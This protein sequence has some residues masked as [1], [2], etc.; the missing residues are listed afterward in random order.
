MFNFNSLW[1]DAHSSHLTCR[2]LRFSRRKDIFARWLN[3]LVIV[4]MLAG[5]LPPVPAQA[6]NVAQPA[7][8]FK[9]V[10]YLQPDNNLSSAPVSMTAQVLPGAVISDTILSETGGVM[11]DFPS[12]E[13]ISVV[14]SFNIT[15]EASSQ[16]G[17][18]T[19][20]TDT[21]YYI[22]YV[23]GS[24]GTI[25]N[26]H[27]IIGSPDGLRATMISS[28]TT[29]KYFTF[30]P[31]EVLS[32]TIDINI[33]SSNGS[34][35]SAQEFYI[36]PEH[37]KSVGDSGWQYVSG[38]NNT[39]GPIVTAQVGSVMAGFKADLD[40]NGVAW[41]DLDWMSFTMQGQGCL[42]TVLPTPQTYAPN[43][44]P[45]CS[46]EQRQ[47]HFGGPINSFSGNYGYQATD[48]NIATRGQ[49]LRLE[50]SYN[51]Q[52]ADGSSDI[53]TRPLGYGWTHNY[54]IKLIVRG[55]RAIF[56]APHGSRM[57][58]TQ[59]GGIYQ[60]D[61]GV[62]AT[63]VTSGG[64]YTL[65]AANQ[66]QFIFNSLGNLTAQIDPHGNQISFTY[67]AA[68][69]LDLVTGP[70][71]V[72]YLDFGYDG[73][74]RLA[75]V[76]DNTG[77]SV[78]YGYD[79]NDNLVTVNDTRSFTWTYTYTSTAL[80][81]GSHL[82]ETVKDPNSRVVEQTVYQDFDG[83]VRA[84]RQKNGL[85]QTMAQISYTSPTERQVTENGRTII[86]RYNAQNF[87]VEQ[88]DPLGRIT[89]Y[90][91]DAAF[92][93]ANTNDCAGMTPLISGMPLA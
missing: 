27:N 8:G 29:F 6:T 32:G 60:A 77:R 42:F 37:G 49:S 87:L 16:P 51:S 68:N 84:V 9:E 26:P 58:F 15:S 20:I 90:A 4:T 24:S 86:D 28:N 66:E 48:F 63:L 67:D 56:K 50:R 33:S 78:S 18:C 30:S 47:N 70:A 92:N 10:E 39:F 73:Q 85:G 38:Q 53:Y 1:K 52:T 71:G 88:E 72:R 3:V 21:T 79:A 12:S 36:H 57:G 5:L 44:C 89:T 34:R 43:E 59:N 46:N 93:R 91:P 83:Q 31:P 11:G 25:Q 14:P 82:L 17:P 75:S 54:D 2:R 35:V 41:A 81:G 7:P 74:N 76:V 40:G 45:S 55:N 62:W 23:N 69:R 22:A 13:K 65:T 80:S 19:P 61:P 64:V